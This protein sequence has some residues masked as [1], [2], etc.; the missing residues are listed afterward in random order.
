MANVVTY[1]RLPEEEQT[2]VEY[3]TKQSEVLGVAQQRAKNAEA[4]TPRPVHEVI[5]Q[6]PA[7]LLLLRAEH[8]DLLK[9]QEFEWEGSPHFSVDTMSSPVIA[10]Q[11]GE[12]DANRLEQSNLSWYSNYPNDK[13]NRLIA[14]P[15]SFVDWARRISAWVRKETPF[16][17]QYKTYR[18]TAMVNEGRKKGLDLVT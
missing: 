15:K 2:F 3:V 18:M 7:T 13:G 9:I 8:R 6:N 5:K 4:L 14:H 11:R 1:W 12:R 17:Y 16:H 10:Y